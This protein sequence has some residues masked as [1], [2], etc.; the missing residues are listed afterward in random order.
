MFLVLA[1][2]IVGPIV[3]IAV[4]VKVAEWIGVLNMFGL[5]ILVS[6]VG[7]LIVKH[8][9]TGTWRRI[10][11]ELGA[12]RVPGASLVDGALILAAGVLLII[13]GF[14]SDGLGLL[15][16]LPPVR[17]VVR[18]ALGRRFRVRTATYPVAGPA[19]TGSI[20]V[21]SVPHDGPTRWDP[22]ALPR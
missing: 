3:E 16:L 17:A 6:L 4:M 13:P 10:R 12:G 11:A 19:R 7:V 9:G 15:L 18:G 8:Q 21:E 2:L 20:D 5:L 14:V 1:L 22:P